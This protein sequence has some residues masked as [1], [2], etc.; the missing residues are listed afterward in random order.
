MSE[1]Q[2]LI[3]H[4]ISTGV[5]YSPSLIKAFQECDRL[6]FVPEALAS[7]AYADHPLPIGEG[8]TISQPSTVAIML[9][10]LEPQRGNHIFDIG[11]GSGWTT[12]L[13]AK[14]VGNEGVVEGIERIPF[15]IGYSRQKLHQLH[16]NNA[17]IELANPAYLGKKGC[18]YDRI[19]VSASA[20]RMPEA[21]FEQLK[22]GGIL[23]VPVEN[24]LW[25]IT[26]QQDGAI[27]SYECAGFSFV[28]LIEP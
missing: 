21:L 26:K 14:T 28:P 12:A 22:Q 15:L 6:K 23:V 27:D 19:L 25:R 4:L 13:L 9:E 16:I 17:S 8:Q 1:N 18:L 11:S 24:S 20:S 3:E 7:F 10:L 5:L 2:H